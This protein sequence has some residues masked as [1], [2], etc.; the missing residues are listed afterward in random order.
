ML[1]DG[2]IHEAVDY[3][4]CMSIST[5]R[6]L[7]DLTKLQASPENLS[8][9]IRRLYDTADTPN[10]KGDIDRILSGL[11]LISPLT[12][13]DDW[14]FI[15]R[16][17]ALNSLSTLAKTMADNIE[18]LDLL[19]GSPNAA[20]A[21]ATHNRFMQYAAQLRAMDFQPT[22]EERA[23]HEHAISEEFSRIGENTE[24]WLEQYGQNRFP[25]ADTDLGGHSD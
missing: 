23:V 11:Y 5:I 12:Y 22:R 17:M 19:V 21:P 2:R 3:V 24:Q 1:V 25:L 7:L 13:L 20:I 18:H 15:I 9:F 14:E 10:R 16:D 8:S 6:S 4:S